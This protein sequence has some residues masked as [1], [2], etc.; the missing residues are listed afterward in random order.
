MERGAVRSNVLA[1]IVALTAAVAPN[2]FSCLVS[3]H[4]PLGPRNIDRELDR[5]RCGSDTYVSLYGCAA[6]VLRGGDPV[7]TISKQKGVVLKFKDRHRRQ[8][9]EHPGITA[10][11]IL[12]KVPTRVGWR[13]LEQPL[14]LN[15]HLPSLLHWRG[16]SATDRPAS[17]LRRVRKPTN[18]NG[19]LSRRP[20]HSASNLPC[21]PP[22]SASGWRILRD[23]HHHRDPSI[24]EIEFAYPLAR[25]QPAHLTR[26]INAWTGR[27]RA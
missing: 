23:L 9:V 24:T 12:I 15:F 8:L 2:S 13:V 18:T 26:G 4:A 3:R 11:A 16:S 25:M 20:H 17:G 21:R 22:R 7:I 1:G 6:S 14:D 27:F 19:S 5:L 10:D